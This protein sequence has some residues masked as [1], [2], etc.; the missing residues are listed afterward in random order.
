MSST[1]IDCPLR[2]EEKGITRIMRHPAGRFGVFVGFALGILA[3]LSITA[4]RS[5]S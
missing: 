1:S 3:A 5:R 2:R 4:G